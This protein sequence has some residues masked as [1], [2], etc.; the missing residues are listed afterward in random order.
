M[1][2]GGA[3]D[4]KPFPGLDIGQPRELTIA[5]VESPEGRNADRRH[6]AEFDIRMRGK[7]QRLGDDSHKLFGIKLGYGALFGGL[8]RLQNRSGTIVELY[9][10]YLV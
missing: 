5:L 4:G 9:Y 6:D 7:A 10:V 3:I 8:R 1:T 2:E